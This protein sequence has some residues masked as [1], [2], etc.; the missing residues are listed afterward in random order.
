MKYFTTILFLLVFS[1]VSLQAQGVR[2][3]LLFAAD[4]TNNDLKL[5]RQWLQADSA[6]VVQRDIWIAIFVDAR[7]FR[8]MYDHHD[9][10]RDEFTLILMRKDGTEQ[11]RSEKPVP[12]K[13]L[14]GLIDLPPA[15]ATE[16]GNN[17]P[18]TN[19]NK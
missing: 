19:Q 6:G 17:K 2:R 5:Q 3:L 15:Q 4:T 16:I 7:T 13:D 1:A 11:F 12:L 8:R 10:D 14:F 18:K 9:V